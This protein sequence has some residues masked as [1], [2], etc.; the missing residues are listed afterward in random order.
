MLAIKSIIPH[1]KIVKESATMRIVSI[2][3]IAQLFVKH[4]KVDI[5]LK[6]S[7]IPKIDVVNFQYIYQIA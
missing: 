3:R 2:V 5:L 7:Q 4:V 6:I 1:G